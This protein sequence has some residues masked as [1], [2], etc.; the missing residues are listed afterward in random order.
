M[1]VCEMRRR[2]AVAL[3]LGM[4][5]LGGVPAGAQTNA[6][7]PTLEALVRQWVDLRGELASEQREWRERE[8]R[9]RSEI[10]L[11]EREAEALRS[12]IAAA[13]SIQE[14]QGREQVDQ[15]ARRE[16]VETALTAVTPVLDRA[17]ADLRGWQ[18]RLPPILRAGLEDAF[19]RLPRE[20]GGGRPGRASER[21]QTILA[22]YAQLESLGHAVHAGRELLTA[23]DGERREVEVLY[24]GLARGFAVAGEGDWA[25]VGVP[26]AEGWSW[27][28]RSGLAPSVRRAL[29]VHRREQ[30][31]GWVALPLGLA[32]ET[33]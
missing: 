2:G 16:R 5:A 8:T 21:I 6:G 17:E 30:T 3:L 1:D 27:T 29:A 11:F 9:W 31:P 18:R 25:A 7:L 23:A 10:D 4:M 32:G 14:A 13:E 12:E 22:L 33:P 26:T 15:L 19:A 20:G 24:L 28:A